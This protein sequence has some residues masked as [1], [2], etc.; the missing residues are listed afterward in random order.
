MRRRPGVLGPGAPERLL[1]LVP[2]E[3]PGP[4]AE[5]W[6]LWEAARLEFVGEHPGG[7]LGDV[8]DVLR[9][10]VRCRRGGW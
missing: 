5:A 8:V 6:R 7:P 4:A 1:R 3:W 9:E 10:H 2:A